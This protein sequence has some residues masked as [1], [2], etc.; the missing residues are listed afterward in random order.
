M[1]NNDFKDIL[2]NRRSIRKYK[3]GVVVD[4]KEIKDIFNAALR[5]PSANNLQP[6]TFKVIKTEAAKNMYSHLFPWNRSQYETSSFMVVIFVDKGYALRAPAIYNMQVKEG[7]MTEAVKQRQLNSFKDNVPTDEDVIKTA[8]LDAGFVA[9]NLML[10]ARAHGYDTCPIGGFLRADAPKAFS[11][12][13]TEAVMALS[14]GIKDDEGYLS[15][16]LPFDEVGSIE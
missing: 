4:D 1:K 3:T 6:W 14:F 11:L 15:L 8:Y 13:G 16:R 10:S 5:A 2:T 7:T 12:E 9:M